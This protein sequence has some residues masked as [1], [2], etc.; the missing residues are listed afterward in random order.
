MYF[1]VLFLVQSFLELSSILF[2]E[3]G[4]RILLDPLE[5]HFPRHW[6]I[7]GCNDDSLMPQFANQEEASA[8]KVEHFK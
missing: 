4:V 7:I 5:E 2:E 3:N 6:W 8:Y 1:Y